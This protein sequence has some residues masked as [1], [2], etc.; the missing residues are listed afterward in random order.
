MNSPRFSFWTFSI[1]MAL[2]LWACGDKST[3]QAGEGSEVADSLPTQNIESKAKEEVPFFALEK[4]INKDLHPLATL[5]AGKPQTEANKYQVYEENSAWKSYQT[6]SEQLWSKNKKAKF[7]TMRHWAKQELA[8]PN[9]AG[10]L[11]FYP[12]S[13]ADFIHADIFFPNADQYLL[14]GLEPIGTLPDIEAVNKSS[15]GA[16]LGSIDRAMH[17]LLSLSFFRTKSMEVDLTGKV[18]KH[19]NGTLPLLMVFMNRLDSEI[20]YYER[21][22]VSKDGKLIGEEQYQKPEGKDSTLYGT[23]LTFKRSGEEKVRTL[24][25]FSADL[26]NA[27]L[28]KRP[29]FVAML[30][31]LRPNSIYIKSASYLMYK[32]YFSTIR[33][34]VLGHTRYY[35]QDDSGMPIN[36]FPKDTWDCTFYGAYTRPID[37]FK[38]Y[39]QKDLRNIYQGNDKDYTVKPLPFGIGYQYKEGTSNLMLAVRKEK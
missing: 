36:Y 23:K 7:E 39:F 20:L 33:N 32:E 25:Y 38:N 5:L 29:D 13:G 8:A 14:I 2:L 3:E 15:L 6:K 31:N 10:G 16:Y 30:N 24:Y 35:L 22:A 9:E 27:G 19:L 37:L 34:I 18:N 17:Y 28:Q 4:R 11:L 26:S 21:V 12:F 1:S